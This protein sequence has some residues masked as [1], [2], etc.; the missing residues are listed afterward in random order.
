MESRRIVRAAAVQLTPVL[1]DRAGSTQKVLDAIADAGRQDIQLLVFPETFI[2]NY[3]YFA[4]WQAP[5]TIAEQHLRLFEQ[6]VEIPGPV[7]QAVGVAAAAAGTVV[8]LGVNERDGGS[9]FNTQVVF[10][11]DGTLLAK[12]RK[13]MPTYQ[14]RMIWGWG[15]G[16][17]LKVLDTAV[18]RVGPLICWEHYMPLS[19]YALM[20]Q[21]EEIHCSHFPGYI[22]RSGFAEEVEVTIRHHAMESGCFVVNATGWLSPDQL[23]E[24]C[25]DPDLRER[26]APDSSYTAI[27][28]PDGRHLAEP[29]TEGEGMVVAD[30]DMQAIAR[31]KL[32]M[33]SV[34]HYA[35]PDVARLLL[36]RRPQ[37]TLVEVDFGPG[38]GAGNPGSPPVE[39]PDLAARIAAL[40]EELRKLKGE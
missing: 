31:R 14:E 12:R 21:R 26:L 22:G 24:L 10:D 2:P 13:L 37:H 6:S 9:L 27:V 20:L 15:D 34:G 23:V 8:V 11:A 39:Y 32:R 5:A 17:D 36:D 7:T 35:R 18:G 1:F 38:P 29:I 4:G 3:P 33:D 25:P 16:S 30:L 19:R 28:G 40:E